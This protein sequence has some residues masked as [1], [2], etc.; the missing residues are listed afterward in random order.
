MDDRRCGPCAN[1]D[2]AAYDDNNVNDHEH[3]LYD[4]HLDDV[5]DDHVASAYHDHL[6][7][8]R[9]FEH[10]NVDEYEYYDNAADDYHGDLTNG[11]I[12]IDKFDTHDHHNRADEHDGGRC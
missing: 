6:D 10:L 11:H 4:Y 12:D 5:Y 1:D 3:H 7:D 8:H 2:D 9:S